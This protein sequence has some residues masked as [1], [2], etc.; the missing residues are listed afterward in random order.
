MKFRIAVV[1]VMSA[2]VLSMTR[3]CA[4]RGRR[5]PASLAGPQEA[6][7][8]VVPVDNRAWSEHRVLAGDDRS[9]ACIRH[10]RPGT[11]RE[12]AL[13]TARNRHV[14]FQVCLANQGMSPL[15][16]GCAVEGAEGCD[17]RFGVW[18]MCRSGT[19]RPKRRLR[20]WMAWDTCRDSCPIRSIPSPSAQ[21]G[22]G[23][24]QSFW[25]TITV[26][27]DATPGVRDLTVRYALAR[28]G[29][30][31]PNCT[32]RSTSGRS[33]VQPRHDFQVT[34]WWRPETIYE[35]YAIEPFGE[36]WWQLAEAYIRNLVAHGN[37]VIFMQQL[38]PRREVRQA[39]GTIGPDHVPVARQVRVRLDECPPARAT[40]PRVAV[41]RISNGRTCGS[42]GVSGTPCPSTRRSSGQAVL[43]VADRHGRPRR[44][45]HQLPAAVPAV[46]PPVPPGGAAARL[47]VL[48]LVGRAQCRTHRELPSS[49]PDAARV[50]TVDAGDG[51]L[52]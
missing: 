14:S 52:E 6:G 11:H 3:A 20:N 5:L 47:L 45:V 51:R 13:V 29:R 28:T 9:L 31:T 30:S 4:A 24:N 41:P 48:P 19:R 22:P 23:E 49:P 50:G 10:L 37:N 42:T 12:L 35:H 26:P 32:R 2:V 7:P 33:V 43:A 34:H 44:G 18:V 39:A 27:A 40:G 25:I 15:D 8:L 1:L 36:R 38:F 46:L 21:V 16:V 17:V